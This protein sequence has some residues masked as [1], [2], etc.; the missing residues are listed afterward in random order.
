MLCFTLIALFLINVVSTQQ[1]PQPPQ[2]FWASG[3]VLSVQWKRNCLSSD[4][5]TNPKF[6]FVLQLVEETEVQNFEFPLAGVVGKKTTFTNYFPQGS[7]NSLKISMKVVGTDP[8]Y[9]IP[10]ECDKTG[11]VKA[12]EFAPVNHVTTQETPSLL[13]FEAKCFTAVIQM[14]KYETIC[15]WCKVDPQTNIGLNKHSDPLYL[16]LGQV[17]INENQ[18]I[19]ILGCLQSIISLASLALLV[20]YIKQK[21]LVLK[22]SPTTTI[23]TLPYYQARQTPLKVKIGLPSEHEYYETIDEGSGNV[24]LFTTMAYSS[25]YNSTKNSSTSFEVAGK[26]EM[27]SNYI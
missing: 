15:P 17:N 2:H 5:C 4:R 12:F 20:L 21:K 23:S 19:I 6:Q 14:Q 10:L 3:E 7:P 18:F 26:E 8:L 11:S 9:N 24:K 27:G 16:A 13:E 25:G 22:K 1:L